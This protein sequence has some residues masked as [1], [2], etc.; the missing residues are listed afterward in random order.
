MAMLG[1]VSPLATPATPVATLEGISQVSSEWGAINAASSFIKSNPYF[2]AGFGLY[3]LTMFGVAGR[4]FSRGFV[5][6]M[7]RRY[8]VSLETTS[9]DPAYSWLMSWMSEH[10]TFSFQQVSVIS[11]NVVIHANEETSSKLT[12]APCPNVPHWLFH[13]GWPIVVQ[14]K[15]QMDRAMGS[16]VLETIELATFGRG[17]AIMQEIAAEAKAQAA[18]RDSDKTVIYHN[19]G[20]RWMRHHDTRTRR[21]IESVIL[22]GS[23]R[24][25]LIRDVR[26]FLGSRDYYTRLGVPYRRGYLLH[27][28]PGCGKSSLVMATAGEL[29]LAI[30]VLSLSSRSLDDDSL[31]C[32]LNEAPLRS[33]MLLEDIDRAFTSDS[34]VTISGLLNALDGVAAQE[35]RL[36][37]MTTNHVEV[38]DPA[39]IRP[40]RADVKMLI[41]WMAASQVAEMF[42][43]FFPDAPREKLLEAAAAVPPNAVSA[44]QLQSHLFLH[45]ESLDAA[46]QSLPEFFAGM[47][48]FEEQVAKGREQRRRMATIPTPPMV[49]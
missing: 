21:P 37:F 13:K 41:G 38:L 43:K 27:G 39:L 10:P 25:D 17:S 14:R 42:R 32:L 5:V 29:R 40:G 44:A 30:C 7:K 12:Y 19:A 2:Q 6:A 11:T 18:A 35:G 31:N 47:R 34:R 26:T 28:P 9:R 49:A 24:D 8:V 33:I 23:M 16:E 3:A 46:L 20:S 4:A 48:K 15:R 1:G 45:R 22:D 36:V